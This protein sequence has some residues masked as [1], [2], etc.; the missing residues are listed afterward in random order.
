M[1]KRY[2]WNA[3]S[4]Q[5]LE[6]D[7][8]YWFHGDD[9][10]VAYVDTGSAWVAAGAPLAA[11]ERLAEVAQAFVEAA[12]AAGR[13]ACLFG[14]EARFSEQVPWSAMLIGEQPVWDPA[15][16][17]AVLRSSRKLR[18]QLR[19]ARAKGVVA[20]PVSPGELEDAESPLRRGVER[21]MARWAFSRPMAPMGFLV[22]L[23]PFSFAGERRYVVAEAGGAVVG[24]LAA[25]PGPRSTWC[26]RR[27]ATGSSPST[28]R[29][30]RSRAAVSCASGSR[31]C[32]AGRPW[33]SRCS[34]GCS[35]RGPRCSRSRPW[36]DGSRHP[37]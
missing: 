33:S 7:F 10:C 25:V 2:G 11:A 22:Q 23:E 26:T 14:A 5:T 12:A 20:R 1:L 19:R 29:S 15:R 4:F 34:A 35:S 18:E 6:S 13:R 21:L 9:A 16:W 17:G 37:R 27:A 30:R 28:T 36:R 24:F 8:R 31:R 32:C 3:T